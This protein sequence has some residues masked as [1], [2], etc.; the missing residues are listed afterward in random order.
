[1]EPE[2]LPGGEGDRVLEGEA[3]FLEIRALDGGVLAFHAGSGE[4]HWLEGLPARLLWAGAHLG[5]AAPER[6][7]E[8]LGDEAALAE[9]M[10]G[11]RAAGL[12]R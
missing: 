8:R 2:A 10:A 11:L 5:G 3:A 12:I 4:T 9:A 1:M 6:L 7:R